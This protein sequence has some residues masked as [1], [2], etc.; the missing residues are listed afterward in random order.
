MGPALIGGWGLRSGPRVIV[1]SLA[2][3]NLLPTAHSLANMFTV[4]DG[5]AFEEKRDIAAQVREAKFEGNLKAAESKR[6]S[7]LDGECRPLTVN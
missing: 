2:R 3:V 5:S 1:R 6:R 7:E 4:I